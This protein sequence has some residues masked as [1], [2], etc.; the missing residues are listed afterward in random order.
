MKLPTAF[1][2]LKR[3][4]RY[5]TESPIFNLN[6][7]YLGVWAIRGNSFAAYCR[8]DFILDECCKTPEH[9]VEAFHAE[10]QQKLS[11]RFVLFFI[12]MME[13]IDCLPCD[14]LIR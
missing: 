14:S 10:F 1:L 12:D 3:T 11:N 2:E 5:I 9:S 7:I 6:K 8:C 4:V 13:N